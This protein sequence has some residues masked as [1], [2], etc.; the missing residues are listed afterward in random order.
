MIIYDLLLLLSLVSLTISFFIYDI[1]VE[2]V[3]IV[4]ESPIVKIFPECGALSDHKIFFEVTGFSP[5]GNVHWEFI[6]SKANIDSYG[7][8]ETDEF[9]GFEEYIIAEVTKP[10]IYILRFFDDKNNNFL[11]DFN[12]S[13]VIINYQIPCANPIF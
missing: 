8:F 9:G 12:G 1:K 7:Y 13:E 4:A 10:D 5:N 3:P 6:D 11:K 2:I